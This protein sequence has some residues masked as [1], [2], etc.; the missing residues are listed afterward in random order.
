MRNTLLP[1]TSLGSILTTTQWDRP[2][3]PHPPSMYIHMYMYIVHSMTLCGYNAPDQ[4]A[5]PNVHG[6]VI[7][8]MYQLDGFYNHVYSTLQ[9]SERKRTRKKET[10]HIINKQNSQQPQWL[11][12]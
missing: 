10:L 3:S 1:P 12:K 7:L 11:R 8:F 4:T 5:S 9:I 6:I 2:E